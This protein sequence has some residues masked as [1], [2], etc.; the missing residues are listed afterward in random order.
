MG[1][2][3]NPTLDERVRRDKHPGIVFRSTST[4]RQAGIEG[5]RLY[6]WQ[7][8]RTVRAS[9]GDVAEAASYLGLTPEQVTAAVRYCAEYRDEVE[10]QITANQE[11]AETARSTCDGRSA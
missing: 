7:V 8:M 11:A 2:V 1:E 3:L 6:V 10:G 9:G 5:R 4:G